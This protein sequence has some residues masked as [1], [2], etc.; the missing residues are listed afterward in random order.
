MRRGSAA[1]SRHAIES[2]TSAVETDPTSFSLSDFLVGDSKDPLKPPRAFTKLH[3]AAESMFELYEPQLLGPA[4]ARTTL[5]YGGR[6]HSVI[7]EIREFLTAASAKV[8]S[9]ETIS[10]I[11]PG[12]SPSNHNTRIQTQ[13]QKRR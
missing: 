2:N 8:E 5:N 7:V 11:A 10:K 9:I 3:E 6:S 12:I 1:S 4:E 13:N